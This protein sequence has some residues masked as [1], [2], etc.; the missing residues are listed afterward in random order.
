MTDSSVESRIWAISLGVIP[1]DVP[2][3]QDRAL[4]GWQ[5]LQSCNEGKG[6][7]LS[8]HTA[9]PALEHCRR[10]LPG[11]RRGTVPAT[12][13][14]PIGSAPAAPTQA[15]GCLPS[16]GGFPLATCSGSG[17]W[18]SDAA[19]YEST[20]GPRT[21]SD[22]VSMTTSRPVPSSS[23]DRSRLKSPIGLSRS[24]LISVI[25]RASLS[26]SRFCSS[27]RVKSIASCF[28]TS[29]RRLRVILPMWARATW[30][31]AKRLL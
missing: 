4:A 18:R 24:G 5:Q 14:L 1:K 23:A 21:C 15:S 12:V 3:N 10:A 16:G 8:S 9:R 30:G 11:A 19:M 26:T 2:Q 20:S 28:H 7:P 25:S 6:L 29:R 13:P 17:L 27:H 31:R 22:P